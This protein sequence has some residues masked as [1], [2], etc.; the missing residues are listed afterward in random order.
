MSTVVQRSRAAQILA[1]ARVK[2]GCNHQPPKSCRRCDGTGANEKALGS[3]AR[4]DERERAKQMR[5]SRPF[6]RAWLASLPASFRADAA[7]HADNTYGVM[8]GLLAE[9]VSAEELHVMGGDAA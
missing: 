2:Q 3:Q 9:V 1:S 8:P 4:S 6:R 7:R 5:T